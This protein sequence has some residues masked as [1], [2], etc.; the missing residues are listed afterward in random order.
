MLMNVSLKNPDLMQQ[1]NLVG[2]EW[3]TKGAA[4]T[5]PV[6]DPATGV[7]LGTVPN[8]GKAETARAIAAAS[9][10][11]PDWRAKLATERADH[12]R[13]LHA[14]ILE[15]QLRPLFGFFQA[16][17]LPIGVYASDADFLDYQLASDEVRSRIAQSVSRSLPIIEQS[18]LV[19]R[20]GYVSTW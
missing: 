10:A 8:C 16:L 3:I 17:T 5:I 18:A 4:G 19:Q 12:L 7:M 11:F 13:R 2:G 6:T 9:Q 15:H 1:A 14:L 20:S